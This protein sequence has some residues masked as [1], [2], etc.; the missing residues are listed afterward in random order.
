MTNLYPADISICLDNKTMSNVTGYVPNMN[1]AKVIC[2]KAL[3]LMTTMRLH[4]KEVRGK[5]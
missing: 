4:E 3:A 2:T 1:C 5:R